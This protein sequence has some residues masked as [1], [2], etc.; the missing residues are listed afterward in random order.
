MPGQGIA[1]MSS[2][3]ALTAEVDTGLPGTVLLWVC[4]P[5][6]I[7]DSSPVNPRRDLAWKINSLVIQG[8]GNEMLPLQEQSH[9]RRRE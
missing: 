9:Q 7:I 6:M 1:G 2:S 5:G 8:M 3:R 4:W